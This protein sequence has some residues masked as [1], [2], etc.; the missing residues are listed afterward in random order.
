MNFKSKSGSLHWGADVGVRAD[1][2]VGLDHQ[3]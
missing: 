2:F 3:P 1:A